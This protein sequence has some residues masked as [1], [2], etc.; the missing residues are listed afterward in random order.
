MLLKKRKEVEATA[1]ASPQ[2]SRERI[3]SELGSSKGL[4]QEKRRGRKKKFASLT[5]INLWC[6]CGVRV[7]RGPLTEKDLSGACKNAPAFYIEKKSM[8]IKSIFQ[9]VRAKRALIEKYIF[10]ASLAFPITH[11]LAILSLCATCRFS[12]PFSSSRGD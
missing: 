3:R 7:L 12:R 6:M 11:F 10:F 1:A 8:R 9:C 4:M 2:K 5:I